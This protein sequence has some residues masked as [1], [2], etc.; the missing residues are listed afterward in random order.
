MLVPVLVAFR[1]YTPR[2]LL[3]FQPGDIVVGITLGLLTRVLS[4]VVGNGAGGQPWPSYPI[5]NGALPRETLVADVIGAALVAPFVE[6]FFFRGVVLVAAFTALYRVAGRNVAAFAAIL[7]STGL[8]ILTHSALG[9][10]STGDALGIFALSVLCGFFVVFTGRIW[11]A[12]LIHAV[13]NASWVALS[14]VGTALSAA[15]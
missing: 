11:P 2:R 10:V 6:E 14:F 4:G 13:Y 12:V 7:L 15:T 5:V 3:S 9:E 1:R 8:F